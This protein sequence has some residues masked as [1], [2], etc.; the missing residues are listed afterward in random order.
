M[1]CKSILRDLAILSPIEIVGVARLLNVD[2][3]YFS[4]DAPDGMGMLREI[5]VKLDKLPYKK[6]KEVIYVIKEAAKE[7][8]HGTSAKN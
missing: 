2:Q 4:K 8:R 3:K 1:K 7:T 5:L 6:A